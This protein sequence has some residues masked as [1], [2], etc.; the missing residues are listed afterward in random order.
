MCD[1]SPASPRATSGT[2]PPPPPTPGRNTYCPSCAGPLELRVPPG[3]ERARLVC[4]SCGSI[5]YEN[6]KVV[7]GSVPLSRDKKRVLL[8]KRAI[9]PVGTWTIPAGFLELEED[10]ESG[11]ARE[12]WEECRARLAK[13]GRLLAVYSILRANQVQLVFESTVLNE[14]SVAPGEESLLV[15]MFEWEEIPWEELSFPT[16]EWVLKYVREH[17]DKPVVVPQVRTKNFDGS[18]SE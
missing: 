2:P 14:E 4:A 13:S 16:V 12:A 3:D 10:A 17:I 8:A 7:V 5:L 15:R 11:A 1:P 6:P 9:P 18:F